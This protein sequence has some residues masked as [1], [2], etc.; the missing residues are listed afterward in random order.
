MPGT[1]FERALEKFSSEIPQEQREEFK[2]CTLQDVHAAIQ[3][4]QTSYGS[5]R[6]LRNMNRIKRFLEGVDHLGKVIEQFLDAA[7]HIG[8]VWVSFTS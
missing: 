6:R 1:C 7:G 5:K 8:F 4:I 2:K 3:A